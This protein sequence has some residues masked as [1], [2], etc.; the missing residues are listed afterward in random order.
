MCWNADRTQAAGP[1]LPNVVTTVPENVRT[2]WNQGVGEGAGGGTG[3]G[4]A[5]AA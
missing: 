2:T 5:A 1:P 4:V 3:T